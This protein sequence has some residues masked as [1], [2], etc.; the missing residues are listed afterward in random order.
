ML[1]HARNAK[2][3]GTS[4]SGDHQNV[5]WHTERAMLPNVLTAGKSGQA[6]PGEARRDV[7]RDL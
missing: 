1:V 7:M 4:T 2:R 6:R 5:I 3:V